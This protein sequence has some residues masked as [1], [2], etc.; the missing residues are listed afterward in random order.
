M[1]MS[2][3]FSFICISMLLSISPG[4]DILYVLTQSVTQGKKAGI[5]TSLGLCTGLI[6]HTTAA[7]FGV[8]TIFEQSMTAFRLLKYAG[9]IYLLVLS[10]KAFREKE[11]LLLGIQENKKATLA[12]YRQGIYMN[13][14]NPKVSLFFLAFLPQF[15][16]STAGNIPGQMIV[17]G[18]LFM[19]QTIIIFFTVAISAGVL[20]SKLLSRPNIEKYIK[21][22][23]TSAFAL[24]GIKLALTE[25]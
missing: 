24:I 14:L 21:Y 10:W 1:E 9:A 15:V 8:S 5:I 18:I 19:L 2:N 11:T 13:L 22:L 7:A 25:K 20:S 23:K 6:V 17:L 12:L 16:D 3:L 4:P